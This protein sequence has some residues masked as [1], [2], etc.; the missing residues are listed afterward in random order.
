MTGRT[1][2]HSRFLLCL[3]A[4]ATSATV[5]HAQTYTDLFDFDGTS[6]GCC[7]TFPG[8]LAQ[9]RDGNLYST[10]LQGGA[11]NRG[12]IFKSTLT[13]TVT[14][15]HN[16]NVTDGYNPQGGLSLG[17]D[18]NFYGTTVSGGSHSAGT[19]FQI[20]PSGTH[21]VI[22]NF[23]NGTDGGFPRNS[24]VQGSDGQFY[25][26]TVVGSNSSIYKVTATGTLTKVATL[27]LE[28]DG[29]LTVATDGKFYGVT[30]VGG[31]SNRGSVFSVTNAGVLKTI[32]S[33]NDPTGA[34]PFGPILQGTDG[35]FYGTA[36][37]GG[38]STGGVVYKLTS[39]GVFTVLHNFDGVNRALGNDPVTGLVQGSDGF[40]YGVTSGGGAHL[41]GTIF[42]IK[43]DGTGFAVVH[44]FDGSH[45]SAPNSQPLL[46]T[47]GKI[48]GQTNTGGSHNDGV[49][50]SLA[51]GLKQFVEPVVIKQAKV[52]GSVGLLGQNF[53]TAT[54]VLFGTGAGTFTTSGNGF[55]TAKPANGDTTGVIT[56]DEPGGNLV[57]PQ[58]FKILP[59]LKTFLPTSGPVGTQ[60][61]LT[62]TSFLQATTVKFG[63][64][65]AT[66][67]V[68]SDT[69]ITTTVP[70]GAVTAKI[71][72]TTPGGTATTSTNFTVQ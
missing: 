22:Y 46:H 55:M 54:S 12:V 4:I 41:D 2:S 70:T 71:S 14:V 68:N 35:N 42:K 58:S 11:N 59:V 72:V 19:I 34:L 7:S 39:A 6:H 21:M 43:T 17:T 9:G 30:N 50:Y 26:T 29:P 45:G 52:G 32:F 48:Y 36:S 38:T 18:G 60:V 66:F 5:A 3:L 53:S 23:T 61:V 65:V 15:L 24:P 25:G 28:C 44:D 63:T 69:Q 31:A 57:S 1:L 13:G 47:N 20:T 37:T 67:T 33:F 10:A 27:G 62:G 16:F 8:V 40:L 49:I 56:V 51:A 64:K